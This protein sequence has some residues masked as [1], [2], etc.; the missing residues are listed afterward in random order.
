MKPSGYLW[1]AALGLLAVGIVIG[2]API[3]S[4]E[5]NCGSVLLGDSHMNVAVQQ[6]KDVLAGLIPGPQDCDSAIAGRQ[7]VVWGALVLGFVAGVGALIAGSRES[8][9]RIAGLQAK[10]DELDAADAADI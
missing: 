4:G 10:L 3:H 7:P 8:R 2:L 1:L 6:S 9:D 5:Y